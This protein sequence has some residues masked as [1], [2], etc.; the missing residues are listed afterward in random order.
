MGKKRRKTNSKGFGRIL[1][2]LFLIGLVL[3]I[4]IFFYLENQKPRVC[5]DAGHG[6][7]R[8]PVLSQVMANNM[9]KQII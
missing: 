5:L 7:K 8:R 6:R 9:K 3:G 2:N 4:S 1:K